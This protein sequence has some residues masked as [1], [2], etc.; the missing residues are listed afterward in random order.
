MKIT[1]SLAAQS[2]RLACAAMFSLGTLTSGAR[3][4]GQELNATLINFKLSEQLKAS[5]AASILAN[6]LDLRAGVD[7][8]RSAYVEHPG[9]GLQVQRFHQYFKGI[10]V[11]HGT[12]SVT[13]K[14]GIA[15]Y[16]FG[17]YFNIN[18]ATSL[19]P[20]IAEAEALDK[21]IQ[22]VGA[23]IYM[24]EADKSLALP[25]GTVQFVEDFSYGEPDGQA[26]L[27]YAFD[28]YA[29]EPLSRY[30]VYVDA[31]SGKILLKDA[32]LKTVSANAPSNYSG[33]LTFEAEQIGSLYYLH[34]LTR[35]SG[36]FTYSLNG[37]T[38]PSAKTE[39][40]STT[41][42]FAKN[43]AIDA[44]WASAR[45]YDYWKNVRNRNGWN[46]T[47]GQQIANVNYGSAVVNAFW[48]GNS[49]N[50]GDGGG[51]YG[52]LVALDVVAHEL[53]HGICQATAGLVYAQE[54]GGMNEGFSDIWG[55]VIEQWADPHETDAVAK[56]TWLVG[57]ELGTPLRSMNNPKQNGQPNTYL[58]SNWIY[59][60][61]GC[62]NSNDNCG[63]H[64]N[65]GVLNYWFYLLSVGGKGT[66]DI[67]NNYEV[68]GIGIDKAAAI[69][70]ATELTLTNTSNYAACRTASIAAATA[71]YGACSPEL[72]A[73]TRAWY[74]VNVGGNFTACGPQISFAANAI[75]VDENAGTDGCAPSRTINLP[76]VL[77]GPAPTG[78]NAVVT[79]TA[80]G[81][82]AVAGVDY[83][84]TSNTAT[85]AAGSTTT[86]NIPV[87][88]YDNVYLGS[89]KYI[90]FALAITAN[91]SNAVMATVYDTVRVVISNDDRSPV[92][93]GPETHQAGLNSSTAAKSSPFLSAYAN[94]RGQ[95]IYTAAELTA[96][97]L[98]AG[99]PINGLGFNVS[100]KHSSQPFTG[101]TIKMAHTDQINFVSTFLSPA[102]KT[103][104]T[105]NV[106][107]ATSWNML[108]FNGGTFTWDGV[109][110]VIV[111]V[112]FSNTGAGSAND[113]VLATAS[114][115]QAATAFSQV[116]SGCSL[117]LAN[118]G[119]SYY[120]PIIRF[121]QDVPPTPVATHA[122]DT[123]S[124]TLTKGQTGYFYTAP[125]KEIIA[126]VLTPNIDL[127]CLTTKVAAAGNGFAVTNASGKRRSI[128]EFELSTSQTLANDT[129]DAI[130][131]FKTEELGNANP[132]DLYIV[133]TTSAN[134]AS[135][136]AANTEMVTPSNII[137]GL[138]W[139]GFRGTFHGMKRFFL[140]EG[141]VLGLP[142]IKG[143]DDALWTGANPFQTAPTLHWNLKTPE[144]VNI[145]L[146]DI[147]GKTVYN[148]DRVLEGGAHS[149]ELGA[150]AS[151]TPGTYVLQVVRP[152]GVFT[153]QLVKQ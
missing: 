69:A 40:T 114:G 1:R 135:M 84:L 28:I 47:N 76:V 22:S 35:G 62:D 78:G 124:W 90:D 19:S 86:Q 119:I 55:N 83:D 112:C 46:G 122:G 92:L 126:T 58:G 104:Y 14:D 23:K 70:Y 34:D 111:E 71:M 132:G 75:T 74:A 89:N 113:T 134:D 37:S 12:Y 4:G 131:Y 139:V 48:N 66:N 123:R 45:A 93:G 79:V 11:A 51:G 53:G 96:G 141:E 29:S 60:G 142:A 85:F 127:S 148:L 150:N 80:V 59:T 146:T 128:K 88:V 91:G 107:T 105:G 5:D 116:N 43:V 57:E 87:T 17:K 7:E 3:E 15:A 30:T 94:A 138:N 152:S 103:V 33:P 36:L 144:H 32:V 26:H 72:E 13:S 10:R 24:W 73:V 133:Q 64:T 52:A 143:T 99:A 63:V 31:Q 27:A 147:T 20:A 149:F 21:A 100:R 49:M 130:F 120:R 137:Y 101:Y 145:R 65:S 110:N 95:Y 97:G 115:S 42:T 102:F 56:N 50:F 121:T 98:K 54:S 16:A 25:K 18:A 9:D 39:I 125:A 136:T 44:H 129:F 151:F 106:T 81:G 153:R 38:S 140:A 67:G 61:A 118:G 68:S 8:L 82:T 108:S 77:N 109:S 41:T 2:L 6:R 117:P